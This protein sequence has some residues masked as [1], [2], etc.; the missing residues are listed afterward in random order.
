ML[1]RVERIQNIH[2]YHKYVQCRDRF[3]AMNEECNEVSVFHGTRTVEPKEIYSS[4]EGLDFRFSDVG[5]WGKANYFTDD[6]RFAHFYAYSVP[7]SNL[8]QFMLVNILAGNIVELEE[9]D[10]LVMPPVLPQNS[11]SRVARRYDTV[12]G[13]H[14]TN[15]RVYV[16]Y[17]NERV[18]PKYLITYF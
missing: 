15:Y 11:A 18:Y 16:L 17:T 10:T 9:D 8:R 4:L 3:V 5:Q 7:D 14:Q 2:L 13:I 6:V 1:F 12:T